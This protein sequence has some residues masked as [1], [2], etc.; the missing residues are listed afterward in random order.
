MKIQFANK[1]IISSLTANQ[2]RT[3]LR[4]TSFRSIYQPISRAYM[5][6]CVAIPSLSDIHQEVFFIDPKTDNFIEHGQVGNVEVAQSQ[7]YTMLRIVVSEKN[8]KKVPGKTFDSDLHQAGYTAYRDLFA[9]IKKY[10]FGTI[11]RIWNYIPNILSPSK[12]ATMPEDR[13]RYRQFNAGRAD[14]WAEYGPRDRQGTLLRPAATGIG[15]HGGPLIIECLTSHYPVT[16]IENP[17]QLPAYTYPK[18]YGTKAPAFARG[19]LVTTPQESQLYIAGTASI[20]GSET[21]HHNDPTAQVKET[22]RN[23]TTLIADKNLK[24]YGE[25]GFKLD[26]VQHYRVYI[27]NPKD[28]P[29]IRKAVEKIIGTQT[30][31][32][33]LNDDICRQDLL[34]E[35]EAIAQRTN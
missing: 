26:D 10:Q 4:L 27:K 13:E 3:V 30:D 1:N 2:K 12:L 35:I 17:R 15:S 24:K 20:V 7:H 31:V 16:Y 6:N 21:L 9:I 34:L 14:A 18:Q 8:Q 29:A 23:I 33:Y 11:A 32:V 25:K 22:F 5:Y 19:S 28:Y